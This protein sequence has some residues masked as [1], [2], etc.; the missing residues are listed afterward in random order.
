MIDDAN[1]PGWCLLLLSRRSSLTRFLVG[2]AEI[3]NRVDQVHAC[4][5]RIHSMGCMTTF[6]SQ[7]RK[8]LP[9]GCIEPFNEGDVVLRFTVMDNSDFSPNRLTVSIDSSYPSL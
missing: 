7:G 3:V 4:F 2:A 6:V 5:Q 1:G 8:P 9:H